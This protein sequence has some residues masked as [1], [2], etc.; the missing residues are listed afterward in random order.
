MGTPMQPGIQLPL[1]N[2]ARPPA[3]ISFCADINPQTTEILLGNVSALIG[4]GFREIHLLLSTPGGS[5]QHGITMYNLL[6]GMPIELIT[7]NTGN[8]DSIG[9]V[10]FLAGKVRRACPQATFMQHGVACGFPG[11]TQ[12]FEKNLQ[13]TLASVQADQGRIADIYKERAGIEKADAEKLFLGETRMTAEDAK[14]RGLVHEIRDVS[15]PNG[16]PVLQ[17]VFNRQ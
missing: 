1:P 6:R 16:S 17:L 4:Q 12:L 14:T 3:F 2:A 9:T 5:V 10:V 8:V 13:E 15:I 7:H 11:P